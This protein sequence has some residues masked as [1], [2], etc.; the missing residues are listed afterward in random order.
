M[1]SNGSLVFKETQCVGVPSLHDGKRNTAVR[2]SMQNRT[3]G[4]HTIEDTVR[5]RVQGPSTSPALG[6]RRAGFPSVHPTLWGSCAPRVPTPASHNSSLTSSAEL[7]GRPISWH[8]CRPYFCS[9]H[10]SP[11]NFRP[12]I[13]WG[14]R[15]RVSVHAASMSL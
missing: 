13:C 3:E 15:N 11:S 14:L 1:L 6:R 7:I 4:F 12:L 9:N 2:R 5:P 10:P 8:A